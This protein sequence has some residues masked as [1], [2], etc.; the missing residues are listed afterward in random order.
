MVRNPQGNRDDEAASAWQQ[1]LA[2]RIVSQALKDLLNRHE[3]RECRE[4]ARAFLA[5]S[6]ML[7]YWCH[8]GRLDSR[9]ISVYA[10]RLVTEHDQSLFGV[11]A[12]VPVV[13]AAEPVH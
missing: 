6:F 2:A 12:P 4:S 8:V 5:G 13:P 3:P 11:P 1:R 9:R 7:H 10:N